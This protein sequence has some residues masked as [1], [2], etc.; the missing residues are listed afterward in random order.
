MDSSSARLWTIWEAPA[1]S[2]RTPLGCVSQWANNGAMRSLC[3]KRFSCL[4]RS[5]VGTNRVWKVTKEPS[6]SESHGSKW[7]SNSSCMNNC[8]VQCKHRDFKTGP[9]FSPMFASHDLSTLPRP[10][11]LRAMA[12]WPVGVWTLNVR[13]F[14]E[15]TQVSQEKGVGE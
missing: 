9:S 6:H 14:V 11:W 12:S 5:K 3:C 13:I 4:D 8:W 10:W 7:R 2:V 1:G 15:N